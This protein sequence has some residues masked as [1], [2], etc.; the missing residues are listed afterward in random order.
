MK[1]L[2][3]LLK[4]ANNFP[5]Y[6]PGNL[7][8]LRM[9]SP[10]TN[11]KSDD[12]HDEW[13]SN[14]DKAILLYSSKY[15]NDHQGF[16]L[17]VK[18]LIDYVASGQHHKDTYGE[19][20]FHAA[21]GDAAD[22]H[23][24]GDEAT[25]VIHQYL[26]D[27]FLRLVPDEKVDSYLEDG[28]EMKPLEDGQ[29]QATA[30]RAIDYDPVENPPG[31]PDWS[32]F[33]ATSYQDFVS[34]IGTSPEWL[35]DVRQYKEWWSKLTPEQKEEEHKKSK[36]E[37]KQRNA[38]Y[39]A[40]TMAPVAMRQMKAG[41]TAQTAIQKAMQ[42]SKKGKF[43]EGIDTTPNKE[44]NMKFL[45]SLMEEA[46]PVAEKSPISK[47]DQRT[48]TSQVKKTFAGDEKFKTGK[49]GRAKFAS[50][51]MDCID[52]CPKNGNCD[53]KHKSACVKAMWGSYR[54]KHDGVT[55][56]VIVEAWDE[57]KEEPL[58]K[59]VK[60]D[61]EKGVKPVKKEKVAK[62]A[63]KDL[64]EE[65]ESDEDPDVKAADDEVKKRGIKTMSPRAEKAL[66]K[67]LD[68]A[69]KKSEDTANKKAK[70]KSKEEVDESF[71]KKLLKGGFA[72]FLN[73]K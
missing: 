47:A 6:Q 59:K 34:K 32:E 23:Y 33:G 4:E 24:D 51:A 15:K 45:R 19:E 60:P 62:A 20:D 55:E 46:K 64:K 50:A 43:G 56:G 25:R 26:D 1:F 66:S 17:F 61:A 67:R 28:I 41:A 71:T 12:E 8:V 42:S 14:H 30:H 65:F 57:S 68:K 2:Q 39:T 10:N 29:M 11:A 63:K 49:V 21:Y 36:K 22:S 7:V 53:E 44:T 38:D 70:E 48:Y 13:E 35:E 40:H 27:G 31:N 73:D 54:A 5:E 69:D 16:I 72:E 9:V 58:K 37:Q 52:N 18:N 3:M